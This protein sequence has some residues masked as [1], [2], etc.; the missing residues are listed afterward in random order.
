VT[1]PFPPP[2]ETTYGIRPHRPWTREDHEKARRYASLPVGPADRFRLR[3]EL[4]GA[5]PLATSSGNFEAVLAA[6]AARGPR[7]DRCGNWTFRPVYL[8][9][10]RTLLHLCPD[11][12]PS[13]YA[14]R[15]GPIPADLLLRELA[16][17]P[18]RRT[19]R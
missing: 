17:G 11:C 14:R 4:E 5:L 15:P 9:L 16:H 8:R 6:I 10:P 13:K 2:D 19:T 18:R 1:E 7:C 12:R 3:M